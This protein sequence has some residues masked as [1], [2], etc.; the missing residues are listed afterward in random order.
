MKEISL[1]KGNIISEQITNLRKSEERA[2]SIAIMLAM[3]FILALIWAVSL[4]RTKNK[5]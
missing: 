2:L 4:R 1:G 5:E 3:G